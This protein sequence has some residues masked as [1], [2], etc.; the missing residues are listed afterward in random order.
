MSTGGDVGSQGDG[1][2][3]LNDVEGVCTVGCIPV[4]TKIVGQ[5]STKVNRLRLHT[6]RL[7][8]VD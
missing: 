5:V 6:I 4:A 7:I 8:Y 1:Q 2:V 3:R